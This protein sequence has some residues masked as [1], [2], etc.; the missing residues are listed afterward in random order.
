MKDRRKDSRYLKGN[1]KP[2]I[3]EGHVIPWSGEKGQNNKQRFTKDYREN[4]TS[5]NRDPTKPRG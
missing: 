5:N 2:Y 4:Q 3:E 1:Q